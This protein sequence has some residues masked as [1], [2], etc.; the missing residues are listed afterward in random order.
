[1]KL[2]RLLAR[3]QHVGKHCLRFLDQYCVSNAPSQPKLY[4]VDV[5]ALIRQVEMHNMSNAM[6]VSCTADLTLAAQ[7]S[8]IFLLMLCI[9]TFL[10]K[11]SM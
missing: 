1:M 8:I 2:S 9:S 4:V 6:M 3:R 11:A 5:L 7:E 10:C